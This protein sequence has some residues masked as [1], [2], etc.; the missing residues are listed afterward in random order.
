MHATTSD[1]VERSRD[2]L[3]AARRDEETAHHREALAAVDSD[4]LSTQ[5]GTDSQRLAF[6]LN[7]Y[8]A[9]VQDR[10]RADPS[11]YDSRRHFF[12]SDQLTVA[13]EAL[14]LN[15]IEH[16][17]LRRSQFWF[18]LGYL[19]NPLPGAF[20]RANRVDERD[21]RIHFAL[22]CGAESCPPIAA[23]DAADIDTDL[24]L[25]TDSFLHATTDYD[26]DT[27]VARVSRLF[28][29]YRGDFGGKSGIVDLLT[30]HEVVPPGSAPTLRYQAYDWSLALDNVADWR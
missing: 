18:G 1:L 24:D 16:G 15:D 12:G 10:L 2:Y 14:S 8:N 4:V 13:G 7:V 9:V 28:L 20:E 30:D 29:W 21:D 5:L 26:P 3:L 25:A 22:N 6:W 11:R 17:L 19:R 23:Y 27:N